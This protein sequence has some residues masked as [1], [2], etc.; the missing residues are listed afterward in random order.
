M[1]AQFT[2]S[3]I[4][5]FAGNLSCDIE[6]DGTVR[7]K[8]VATIDAG[9]LKDSPRVF[10]MCGQQLCPPGPFTVSSQLPGGQLTLDSSPPFPERSSVMKYSVPTLSSN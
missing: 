6:R 9:I 2:W 7:I 10:H 4:L 3:I 1:A 5:V 8:G